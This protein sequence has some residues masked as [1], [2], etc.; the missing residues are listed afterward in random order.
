MNFTTKSF[1]STPSNT[2]KWKTLAFSDTYYWERD[3]YAPEQYIF[4]MTNSM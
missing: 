1:R 4:E 3:V 2:A